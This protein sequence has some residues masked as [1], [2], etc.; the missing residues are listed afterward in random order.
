MRLL[1]ICFLLLMVSSIS[2]AQSDSSKIVNHTNHLDT[3][4]S[5]RKAALFSAVLPGLGQAYNRKYWKIPIVYAALGT[6]VYFIIDNTK[7]YRLHRTEYLY[8]LRN[9]GATENF[10]LQNFSD[11]QLLTL[12]SQ[13]QRWRDMSIAI[14]AAF[15][16]LQ[17]ID[18]TV[19]AY[20]WRFDKSDNLSF[21]F[22]P[23]LLNT[24]QISPGLKLSLKF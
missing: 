23:T 22:R 18:A 14:T 13:Y 12:T 4:H 9:N 5:P 24:T 3:L 7:N 1:T 2:K 15:Y 17:I 16:A 20:L 10:D 19:D 11:G 8:R 6:S 21:H